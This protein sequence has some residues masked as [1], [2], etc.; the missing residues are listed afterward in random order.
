MSG[1]GAPRAPRPDVLLVA[2]A[3]PNFVKIAPI[4][5]AL[6]RRGRLSHQVLHTGQ[7]HDHDMS[8][9][10]F[11]ELEIAAPDI[12]LGPGGGSH[13][14]QT[15]RIMVA[16][17]KLLAERGQL[18]VVVVGDVDSTLAC[19]L[20]AAKAR[21]PVAH[22]EA[23][24]R[25]GDRSMPEEINR[26]VTD[27]VSDL[28]LTTCDDGTANLE[29]EGVPPH[30]IRQPGNVMIDTLMR[31][32][33]KARSLE[34]WPGV[35]AAERYVLCTLH[36]PSNVDDEGSLREVTAILRATAELAPVIL[37]LHPRTTRNLAR[38]GLNDELRHPRIH[39]LPALSY[40]NFLR[41]VLGASVVLTDSGGIQE[42]TT[43]LGIPCVT[44]RPNTERPVTVEL[45]TNVLAGLDRGEVTAHVAAALAGRWKPHRVP[46]GWDGAAAERVV[47]EL[48]RFLAPENSPS[49]LSPAQ[50]RLRTTRPS[51]PRTAS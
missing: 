5:R 38:F 37:P 39:P 29:R 4:T 41:V 42:E 2:G 44:L 10:F 36:R 45:G 16:F 49:A 15:A 3:R 19:S 20:T 12:T 31:F 26:I 28:L 51:D 8:R 25:S 35:P 40:L 14:E 32:L 11:D 22:V 50:P 23:G 24:L 30:R 46:E 9:V 18:L 47:D 21:V 13:A 1:S 48:E 17:E 6:S 33:P 43:V 34:P 7:H 27:A